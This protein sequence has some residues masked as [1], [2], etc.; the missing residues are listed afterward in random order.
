MIALVL[1]ILLLAAG[2]ASLLGWTADSRDPR[3]GLGALTRDRR[4]TKTGA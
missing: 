1:L 4:L 2:A 3:F